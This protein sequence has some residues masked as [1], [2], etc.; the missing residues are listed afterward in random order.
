MKLGSQ[1]KRS[2]T[3]ENTMIV[4]KNSILFVFNFCRR[5]P[6]FGV[7]IFSVTESEH[8]DVPWRWIY[9][10]CTYNTE[11]ISKDRRRIYIYTS[12]DS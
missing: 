10:K 1:D 7:K 8:F 9:E 4:D 2:T 5:L 3:I 12:S 6:G 11:N